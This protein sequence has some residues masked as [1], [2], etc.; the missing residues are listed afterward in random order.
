MKTMKLLVRSR[1][2]QSPGIVS[3]E[4]VNADGQPLPAFEAGAHIDVHLGPGLIRQYSLCNAPTKREAY[5]IGVLLEPKSRGGS[6]AVHEQVLAGKMV[7]VGMP[8]NLFPLTEA[9]HYVLVGAGI[10]ITPILAMAEA[11]AAR[12]ASFDAHY[13]ART[14]EHVAF[15][16]R[17]TS[18]PLRDHFSIHVN[19]A[20]GTDM[21][22]VQRMLEGAAPDKHIYVC[23][24]NG[25]I[26][27]LRAQASA[28]G[29]ADEN[30]RFER[31]AATI[32]EGAVNREFTVRLASTNQAYT[33]PPN[34][35]VLNV[36]ERA[37]VDIPF[38]CEQGVCGACVTKVIEG[39][40]DH[41]DS[42][43]SSK[44]KASG[45]L[46]MPCRS[47]ATSDLLVL[48]L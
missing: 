27:M 32:P 20:E 15:R 11:L 33:I 38:S 37:G 40:I 26:E 18:A 17:I 4:L 13:F 2:A 9:S 34:E 23:G 19:G 46:F 5:V 7:T 12:G 44:E 45:R 14:H 28:K 43:L 29:W 25:F 22:A 6:K 47:R 39:E 48:D 21:E 8:R 16:A 36:L 30:V 1:D 41:R 31:F 24:P 10:G 3:L 35:S 42:Y